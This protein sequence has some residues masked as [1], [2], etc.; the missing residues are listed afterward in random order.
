MVSFHCPSSSI[1]LPQ[2]THL[3]PNFPQT[4]FFLFPKVVKRCQMK[5]ED[6]HML[7]SIEGVHHTEG[8]APSLGEAHAP[9]PA[10]LMGLICWA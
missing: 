5:V 6:N 1:F 8:A 10:G 7:S 3:P 4:S 2:I 9:A